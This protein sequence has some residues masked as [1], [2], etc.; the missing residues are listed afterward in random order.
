MELLPKQN[1]QVRAKTGT[2]RGVSTYAGFVKRGGHWEPFS[3]LINQ[4]VSYNFRLQVADSLASAP[5]LTGLCSGGR[6]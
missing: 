4:P 6:C 2:L 3:L 5:D 1:A